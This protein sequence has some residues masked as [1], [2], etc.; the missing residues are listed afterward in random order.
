MD[1]IKNVVVE[2]ISRFYATVVY[3]SFSDGTHVH[4]RYTECVHCP[5]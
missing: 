1:Q 3:L 2:N 5:N 4:N